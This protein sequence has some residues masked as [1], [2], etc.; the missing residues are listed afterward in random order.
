[1]SRIKTGFYLQL[2]TPGAMNLLG[3]IENRTIKDDN[4]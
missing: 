1:M 2:L 4:D 3:S